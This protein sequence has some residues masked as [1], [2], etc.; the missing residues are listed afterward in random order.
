LFAPAVVRVHPL[1]LNKWVA[2]I[3]CAKYNWVVADAIVAEVPITVNAEAAP[4][5]PI[6]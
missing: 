3:A 2:G 5:T 4:T 1:K 6:A